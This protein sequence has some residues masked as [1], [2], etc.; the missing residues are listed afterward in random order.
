MEA[1]PVVGV[2]DGPGELAGQRGV[3]DAVVHVTPGPFRSRQPAFG[4]QGLGVGVVAHH[5]LAGLLGRLGD[6]GGAV[7]VLGDDV[8]ALGEEALGCFGLFGWVTPVGGVHHIGF[9]AG[10]DALRTQLERVDVG[11]GL[12]DGKG[13]D[14]AQLVGFG[15]LT[16]GDASQVHRLVHGTEVRTGVGRN[17]VGDEVALLHDDHIGVGLGHFQSR[18]E[19]TVGGSEDDLGPIGDH[20]F[21]HPGGVVVFW[22]VFGGEDL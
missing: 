17:R 15:G 7:L 19:V 11:D 14:I 21:H 18:V 4:G 5:H 12:G 3:H 2:V 13:V 22:H 8:D 10:V 16:G 6:G 20:L 9:D 1:H